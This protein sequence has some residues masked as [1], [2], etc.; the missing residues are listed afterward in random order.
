M[1]S[2]AENTRPSDTLVRHGSAKRKDVHDDHFSAC[3]LC[4]RSLYC[5]LPVLVLVL[6]F[7]TVVGIITHFQ[8]PV[9]LALSSLDYVTKRSENKY[10]KMVKGYKYVMALHIDNA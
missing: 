3:I 8:F 10:L 4:C 9:S 2:T 5:I 7:N 6:H 1:I